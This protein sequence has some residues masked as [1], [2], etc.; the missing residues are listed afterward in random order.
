[1]A[2]LVIRDLFNGANAV[3]RQMTYERLQKENMAFANTGGISENNRARG[4][5]PAFYDTQTGRAEPSRFRSGALAP[6]HLLDGLP[7][8]W[9][10][11]RDPS[12]KTAAIKETVIA[13]FLLEGCFYT[14]EQAAKAVTH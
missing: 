12:G 10:V 11:Q 1:M 3:I 13:G 9:V 6:M 7:E 8:E 4:F 2:T 14:R 5:I